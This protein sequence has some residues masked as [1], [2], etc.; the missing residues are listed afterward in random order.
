MY[1]FFKFSYYAIIES[2]NYVFNDGTQFYFAL[3]EHLACSMLCNLY[4][5]STLIVLVIQ[6]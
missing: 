5:S 6:V 4:C 2:Y 1:M 3:L